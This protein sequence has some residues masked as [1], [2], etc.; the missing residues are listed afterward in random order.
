MQPNWTDEDTKIIK[1]Y[2]KLK[3]E[4]KIKNF[5]IIPRFVWVLSGIQ[6]D[7]LL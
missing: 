6:V 5:V 4:G 7:T 1:E 2:E 3:K